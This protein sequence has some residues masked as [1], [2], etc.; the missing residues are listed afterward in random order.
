MP[1]VQLNQLAASL[2]KGSLQFV[3]VAETWQPGA[4]GSATPVEERPLITK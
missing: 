1:K 3:G 2:F 4:H